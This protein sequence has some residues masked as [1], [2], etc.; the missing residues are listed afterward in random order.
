MNK[1]HIQ[2]YSKKNDWTNGNDDE[3][4]VQKFRFY[5]H[6]RNMAETLNWNNSKFVSL[7]IIS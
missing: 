3:N 5:D 6:Y 7:F 1:E 2:E 4:T